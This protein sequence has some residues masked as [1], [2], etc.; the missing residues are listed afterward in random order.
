MIAVAL[1]IHRHPNITALQ[2]MMLHAVHKRQHLHLSHKTT[3]QNYGLF[4]ALLL[5]ILLS[6]STGLGATSRVS[7]AEGMTSPHD[8]KH[9]TH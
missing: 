9:V 2:D 3:T 6:T 5:P 7:R 4:R 8:Q 1:N